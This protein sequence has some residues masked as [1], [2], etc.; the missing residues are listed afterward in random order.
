M[1]AFQGHHPGIHIAVVTLLQLLQRD[2]LFID[3]VV[4]V[5]LS[6]LNL[7]QLKVLYL[8]VAWNYLIV[9]DY[10]GSFATS[11]DVAL[12]GVSKLAHFLLA[13]ES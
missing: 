5:E 4:L 12:H 6:R 8:T 10:G 1:H 7:E 13:L 2:L 9:H 3:T 11:A